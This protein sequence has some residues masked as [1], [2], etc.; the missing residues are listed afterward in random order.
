MIQ[1][2]DYQVMAVFILYTSTVV[3]FAWWMN[4]KFNG[5]L[6]ATDYAKRHEAM[7]ERIRQLEI[8]VA[9]LIQKTN[10]RG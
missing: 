4:N 9:Q 6:P 10:I 8:K 3:G 5:L 1:T 2:I 7:E